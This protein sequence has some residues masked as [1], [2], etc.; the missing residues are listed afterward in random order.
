M[1]YYK[2][3]WRVEMLTKKNNNI[4]NKQN[5][6]GKKTNRNI[7]AKTEQEYARMLIQYIQKEIMD[8]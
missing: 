3:T 4:Y 1:T 6:V 7:T 8:I 2:H 5:K